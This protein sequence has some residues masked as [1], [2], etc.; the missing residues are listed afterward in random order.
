MREAFSNALRLSLAALHGFGTFGELRTSALM[1]MHRMVEMLSDGEVVG[2]LSPALPQLL[3]AA[4]GREVVEVS[5]L[6]NQLVL[7]FKGKIAHPVSP[8]V[9]HLTTATFGHIAQLD[10]Q[11]A[12]TVTAAG[13]RARAGGPQSHH[14]RERYAL[15]RSYYGL[16]H[17]LVHSELLGVLTDAANA[18]H[19]EAALRVLLQG[20]TE[21]PDLQLQRQCFLVLH[22]LVEEWCAAGPAQVAGFDAFALQQARARAPAAPHAPALAPVQALVGRWARRSERGTRRR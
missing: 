14:E 10:A 7:K 12:E 22:R 18:P 9:L 2:V 11:I 8:M 1:L 17:S 15:L 16:L 5:R 21:G 3:S 19:V 20:C 4:E 6:V 13:L